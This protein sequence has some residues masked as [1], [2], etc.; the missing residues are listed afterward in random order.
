VGRER[1]GCDRRP[2]CRLRKAGFVADYQRLVAAS[3]SCIA[4]VLEREAVDQQIFA[5]SQDELRLRREGQVA[6][7]GVFVFRS[8]MDVW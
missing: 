3:S 4:D 6:V 1:S 8:V 7:E 2:S 5:A